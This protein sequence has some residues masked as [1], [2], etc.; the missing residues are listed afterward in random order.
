MY[1]QIKKRLYKTV[2][3][4]IEKREPGGRWEGRRERERQRVRERE[5]D[6]ERETDRQTEKALTNC[7]YIRTGPYIVSLAFVLSVTTSK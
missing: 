4:G 6:R 2:A 5:K 7:V 1:S 3:H